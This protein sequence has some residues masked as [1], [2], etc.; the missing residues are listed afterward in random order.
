VP[1]GAIGGANGMGGTD[2]MPGMP[3]MGIADVIAADASSSWRQA[4]R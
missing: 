4:W 3:G 2:G 1:G